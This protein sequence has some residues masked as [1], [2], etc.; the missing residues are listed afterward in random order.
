MRASFPK[1]LVATEFPP[2]ASGGGPAVVRQ[3]LKSWPVKDLFWWSCLP[4]RNAGFGQQV[5]IHRTA[6]IPARFYPHRRVRM[7]K[8]WLLEKIWS[9][10][11]AR[12]LSKTLC[13][14][15]PDV[16]WVIP[17]AWAILPIA[18]TL[19]SAGIRFHVTIQDFADSGAYARQFG[20]RRSRRM[21]EMADQLYTEATT[22]DATSH[23]MIAHLR[24]RTGRD[25][26]QVLHSGL[27]R[28]DFEYLEKKKAAPT[29]VIHI[30]YAG[31]ITAE[32]AFE[33]F[34]RSLTT[35][36]DRFP[37]R[38][39]LELFGAHSYRDRRWFDA[40]WMHEH[41]NL[42]ERDLTRALRDCTW[43]LSLMSF[44]END[45]QRFSFPTKFISYLAAGLPVFTLGH[46]DCS[47]IEMA[48]EYS[49]GVCVTSMEED[50]LR[51]TMFEALSTENPW[52]RFGDG[53]LRCA[54]KEFAAAQKREILY[55]CL[56]QCAGS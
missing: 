36:R 41:G 52:E 17:H 49:V 31:T 27:E 6:T 21:A 37:K 9:K 2:N 13:A 32:D 35:V 43:G 14:L 33:L 25:A 51:E 26:M 48:R 23:S 1:L 46:T 50:L 15:K 45:P 8:S 38:I 54:R 24:Q 47:V 28:N 10:W 55:D 4:E 29:D 3:M 53:I 16:V 5:A 20:L 11:A 22:R 34:V 7:L 40:S 56:L 18:E 42:P 12:H 30:A 19:R 44:S 39:S